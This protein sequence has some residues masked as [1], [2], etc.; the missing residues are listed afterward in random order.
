M[1][2]FNL[3]APRW[4][5]LNQ[6]PQ[7]WLLVVALVSG[8]GHS[9]A[10]AATSGD[11]R[12]HPGIGDPTPIGWITVWAYA[13][14]CGLCFVCARRLRPPLFWWTVTAALLFLGINKQLDLQTW[15]TEVG[16]DLAQQD[17]WYERRHEIQVA[18][19]GGMGL[20]FACLA[21]MV[22]WAL[23]GFWRPYLRVWGGMALLM[24]FIVVRAASFHHVDQLLM[25]D[26]GGLR[27]NWVFEL[28]G[29][30]LIASGA[31]RAKTQGPQT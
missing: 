20:L 21:G 2:R 14:T 9:L 18:F 13:G 22:A 28:G 15:F 1:R 16:R 10:L 23:K 31:W 19:I 29:L 5:R 27:M 11:G 25:S 26:I 24:F 8:L 30:G 6:A 17:G 7:P 4:V 3:H 12:W